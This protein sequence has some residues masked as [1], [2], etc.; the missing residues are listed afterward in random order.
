M[1]NAFIL[2]S[3]PIEFTDYFGW[4]THLPFETVA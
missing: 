1:E 3:L 4:L 2:H